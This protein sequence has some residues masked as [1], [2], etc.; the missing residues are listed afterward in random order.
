MVDYAGNEIKEGQGCLSCAYVKHEFS[1]PAGMAFENEMFTL[2][3][4]WELPIVGFFVVTPKRHVESLAE[5]SDAERNAMFTLVNE[6]IKVL[7]KHNVCEFYNVIFEEKPNRH[8]H[9]WLMP[10][11]EWLKAMFGN[12]TKH[13]SEIFD[14]A[15]SNLRNYENF[16]KIQETTDILKRELSKIDL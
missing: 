15:K 5:L 3:Q 11:H 13:I 2:S 10:R 7:K 4:D 9:I 14:Y 16:K 12:P 8:L 6:A 1:L